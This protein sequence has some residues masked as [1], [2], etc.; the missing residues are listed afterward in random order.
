M[1]RK[2]KKEIWVP[3]EWITFTN[4]EIDRKKVEKIKSELS[5]IQFW[6][7]PWYF[8]VA[9]RQFIITDGNHRV[10]AMK[11]LGYSHVPCIFLSKKEFEFIAYSTNNLPYIV[12]R[13]N[14]FI[15][16][17][18]KFPDWYF[19]EENFVIL[20]VDV[21]MKKWKISSYSETRWIILKSLYS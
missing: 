15:V 7:V 6:A 9:D 20:V 17:L 5:R 3:I 8:A 14:T 10:T 19:D 11:E 18:D 16:W 2:I 13:S 21:T 1:K 4:N 12:E